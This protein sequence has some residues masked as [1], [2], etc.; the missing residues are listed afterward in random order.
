MEPEHIK[1]SYNSRTKKLTTISKT[2][3][4]QKTETANKYV[5]SCSASLVAKEM[6]IKTI[7]TCHFIP[8]KKLIIPKK[9][10]KSKVT[11]TDS[12]LN[13]RQTETLVH[14]WIA[15]RNGTATVEKIVSSKRLRI[16]V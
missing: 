12:D 5:R 6:Q 1:N 3:I 8:I 7:M 9:K 11:S 10:K 4:S 15:G 14:C 13:S 16:T 2:D